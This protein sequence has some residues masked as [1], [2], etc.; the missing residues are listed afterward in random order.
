MPPNAPTKRIG[1]NVSAMFTPS[2]MP[3]ACERRTTSHADAV[4]FSQVPV[5]EI[6]CPMKNSRKFR[7]RSEWNVR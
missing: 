4:A 6:A 2:A 7:V 3:F 5:T 1:K